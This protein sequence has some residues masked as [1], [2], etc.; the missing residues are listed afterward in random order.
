MS[1]Y[2]SS[3]NQRDEVDALIDEVKQEYMQES[4]SGQDPDIFPE[5]RGLYR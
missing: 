5:V 2:D 1:D 3:P 4:A